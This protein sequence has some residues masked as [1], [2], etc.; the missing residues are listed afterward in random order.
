MTKSQN[1]IRKLMNITTEFFGF[2][3]CVTFV[4]IIISKIKTTYVKGNLL[5]VKKSEQFWNSVEIYTI[6]FLFF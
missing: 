2:W 1:R 3:I 5:E 6:Y 4:L